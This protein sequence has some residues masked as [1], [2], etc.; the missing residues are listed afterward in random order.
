MKVVVMQC[1][2]FLLIRPVLGF[3]PGYKILPST[4]EHGMGSEWQE[5]LTVICKCSVQGAGKELLFFFECKW[6]RLYQL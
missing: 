4:L 3:V 5:G 2:L 6:E 1:F